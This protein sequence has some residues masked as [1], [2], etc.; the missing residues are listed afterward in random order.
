MN[1]NQKV[2]WC[3]WQV[4]DCPS[5]GGV[6]KP[7]IT[8]FGDN[9]PKKTVHMLL[10]KMLNSDG[11][12]VIGSSLKVSLKQNFSFN[13]FKPYPKGTALYKKVRVSVPLLM[14]L[15]PLFS[16]S[17]PTSKSFQGGRS[18]HIFSLRQTCFVWF[19]LLSIYWQYI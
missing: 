18:A 2:M 15:P 6:L 7:E 10:E 5:C 16:L 19:Y 1:R 17:S 4:P 14:L 8:F 11:V 3:F 9:V 13:E 12:L